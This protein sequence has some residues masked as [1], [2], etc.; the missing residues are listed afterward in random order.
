[1]LLK[2]TKMLKYAL[3]YFF[4]FRRKRKLQIYKGTLVFHFFFMPLK[5]KKYK[6]FNYKFI[7]F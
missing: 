6:N 2:F 4:I 7:L 5:R 3:K 1:M